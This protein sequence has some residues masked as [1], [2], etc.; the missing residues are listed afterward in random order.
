[1][2][3]HVGTE[4]EQGP[5]LLDSCVWELTDPLL[6]EGSGHAAAPADRRLMGRR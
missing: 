2:T 1:M 5:D 3:T 4:E 6:G